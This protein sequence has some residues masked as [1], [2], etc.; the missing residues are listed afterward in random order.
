MGRKPL[1]LRAAVAPVVLSLFGVLVV[2]A[3]DAG[4]APTYKAAVGYPTQG[5]DPQIIH[6]G[7]TPQ[8][9]MLATSVPTQGSGSDTHND[10]AAAGPAG[11]RASSRSTFTLTTGPEEPFGG[12]G[13]SL[14]LA[15]AT[16]EVDDLVF[17]GT[18]TTFT[19]SL[20]LDLSGT[21][22]T[23]VNAFFNTVTPGNGGAAATGASTTVR[24]QV[25]ITDPF[26]PFTAQGDVFVFDQTVDSNG[27]QSGSLFDSRSITTK[28][29]TLR[30]GRF[31]RMLLV[32]QAN[33]DSSYGASG[34]KNV[35]LFADS[36]SDFS[37]TLTFKAGGD[38]FNLPAGFTANSAESQIV[39]N[40]FVPEPDADFELAAFAFG[41]LCVVDRR[42][43]R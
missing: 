34:V 38:V 30:T 26:F 5:S 21:F 31:Y 13:Q 40:S 36:L 41:G 9:A 12:S 43:R 6:Q 14:G 2:A 22:A 32:L 3:P 28:N 1:T 27:N 17:A 39:A 15:N 25:V 42:C 19:T 11:L 16:S 37:H 33:T 4:A 29:F 18:G 24:V 35:N 7:S 10:F 8:D 20:N 23:D